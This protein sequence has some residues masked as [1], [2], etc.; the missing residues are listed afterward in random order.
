MATVGYYE[1]GA[2]QG[3]AAQVDEITNNGD[4]AVNVTVPDAAQLA[5]LDTLYVMNSSNGN[6]GAEYT[7]NLD[8]IATAV[9]GGMNLMIFD[10]FVTGAETILPGGSA[11]TAVR[12]M[13]DDAN[14]NIAAGA[15]SVF[16]NGA[17][18]TL[19]DD[20][21]DGGTSSNHGYVE[22]SSLPAGAT[23]LL[24]T[25]DQSH[26]VA[27]TYPF[28]GG[29]VFYSTIPLDYYTAGSNAAITQS[30]IDILFSN[31]QETMLC[32]AAGTLIET[33][34]GPTPVEALR[35][36]DAVYIV[37]GGT[38]PIR[39]INSS[40]ACAIRLARAP[41]LAPVRITAGA[42]GGGLPQRDLLV[43]RQHR[44]LV[45]SRVAERMFGAPEVLVSAIRLTAL[46]GIYVDKSVT[47]VEYFHIL[48]DT[49]E[50]IFAEGAPSE[51]L[52]TGPEAMR[53]IPTAARA[54]LLTLFPELAT[55]TYT[56]VSAAHIPSGKEQK[57]L[58][59]RH[60]KNARA[61]VE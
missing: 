51:S 8:A 18:G 13:T 56:A 17:A 30:E 16:T 40:R 1:M 9:N 32:F 36:D 26:V 59:I 3:L 15:P 55:L 2:G 19:D 25:G 54:E 37:R 52:F 44:M 61:L 42:L 4:T 34:A 6:F 24:T 39:W 60:A 57:A 33:P 14:V 21:F 10:R 35:V 41:K 31:L 7:A 43:S 58:V 5:S 50:I 23:A 53:S 46:P 48:F 29:N 38:A 47:E 49:H 11:I 28:G 22:L 45:R 12:D 27:F 20:T